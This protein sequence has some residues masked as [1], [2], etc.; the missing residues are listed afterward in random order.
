MLRTRNRDIARS[1]AASKGQLYGSSVFDGFW[2]TGTR[3]AL[4]AI[5]CTETVDP[6]YDR[7]GTLTER[8]ERLVGA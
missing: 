5:G 2:Y 1:H 4:L 8:G 7:D 6:S 3:E